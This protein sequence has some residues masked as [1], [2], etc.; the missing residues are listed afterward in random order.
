VL[1]A[2]ALQS[3]PSMDYAAQLIASGTTGR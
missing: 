3:D 2:H 1:K